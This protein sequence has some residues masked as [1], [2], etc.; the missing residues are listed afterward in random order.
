MSKKSK[1][2]TR[3]KR[4]EE[5]RVRKSSK[6]YL[7]GSL[8][9]SENTG[10]STKRPKVRPNGA[11]AKGHAPKRPSDPKHPCCVCGGSKTRYTNTDGKH[12]DNKHRP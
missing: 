1:L 11:A 6:T 4:R 12:F 2:A 7:K 10:S 8:K 3:L 9:A 5:K